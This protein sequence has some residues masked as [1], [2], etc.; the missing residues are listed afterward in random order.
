MNARVPEIKTKNARLASLASITFVTVSILEFLAKWVY[1]TYMSKRHLNFRR[2]WVEDSRFFWACQY[3]HRLAVLYRM[4]TGEVNDVQS[5]VTDEYWSI[6]IKKGL[7]SVLQFKM[8]SRSSVVGTESQ[9]PVSSTW[10]RS[11]FRSLVNPII[12]S[13]ATD[14][15]LKVME[16]G[17]QF[18]LN[19]AVFFRTLLVYGFYSLQWLP[20]VDAEGKCPHVPNT[21]IADEGKTGSRG[22]KGKRDSVPSAFKSWKRR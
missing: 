14:N 1:L 7:L 8:N 12:T 17:L 16:V 13:R 15:V 20:I 6:N 10:G 22:R 2:W 18:M 9:R 3:G 21:E 19:V 11:R 5:D 4:S